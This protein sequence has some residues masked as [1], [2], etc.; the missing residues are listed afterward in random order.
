MRNL[1]DDYALETYAYDEMASEAAQPSLLSLT[2][3]DDR[4]SFS[5]PATSSPWSNFLVVTVAL[6]F[7]LFLAYFSVR[8]M[9]R[10]RNGRGNRNINIVEGIGVGPQAT[11]QLIKAG[12]KC[13]LIGVSRH[14]ITTIGEVDAETIKIEEAAKVLPEIPFDKYLA[15][16]TKKKDEKP[17]DE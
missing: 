3:A 14:G 8:V 12:D 17:K 16:F 1:N 6:V 4:S 15:R 9:G 11:V 13:F 10:A 5:S 2:A 7:V